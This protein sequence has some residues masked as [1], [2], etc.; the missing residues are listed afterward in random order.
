MLTSLVAPVPNPKCKRPCSVVPASPEVT[1]T[2][3]TSLLT[4]KAFRTLTTITMLAPDIE[5]TDLDDELQ[6]QFDLLSSLSY[7][8]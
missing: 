5:Q 7:L 6:G 4:I 2:T 1:R 3:Q 8:V